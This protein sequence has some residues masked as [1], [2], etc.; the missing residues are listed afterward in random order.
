VLDFIYVW[1]YNGDIY[2]SARHVSRRKLRSYATKYP[3]TVAGVAA[4]MI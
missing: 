3:K 2:E 1:R 4:G